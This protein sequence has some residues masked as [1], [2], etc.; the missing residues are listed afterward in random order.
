[1]IMAHK[2][3]PKHESRMRV[4]NMTI[5]LATED[6]TRLIKVQTGFRYPTQRSAYEA[7]AKQGL[8]VMERL[9]D[10]LQ[11]FLNNIEPA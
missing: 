4:G 7:A 5:P 10:V 6:H 2:E 9:L 11:Q 8:I 3:S 1:L